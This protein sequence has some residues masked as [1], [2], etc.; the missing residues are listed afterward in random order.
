M[1]LIPKLQSHLQHGP[2]D[3]FFNAGRSEVARGEADV[4]TPWLQAIPIWTRP[5]VTVVAYPRQKGNYS[6]WRTPRLW[7]VFSR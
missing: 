7:I 4:V 6:S 5:L 2:S 1:A 3:S